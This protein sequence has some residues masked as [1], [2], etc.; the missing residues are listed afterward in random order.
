MLDG[1]LESQPTLLGASKQTMMLYQAMELH[2]HLGA[3]ELL[4]VHK[5]AKDERT[6]HGVAFCFN[7][8]IT[9]ASRYPL[10]ISN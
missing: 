9:F 7:A 1:Y 6:D 4:L 8:P 3:C 2:T 5:L 10:D